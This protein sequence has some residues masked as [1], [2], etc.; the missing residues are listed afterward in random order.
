MAILKLQ[1][2]GETATLSIKAAEVVQGKFGPQVRFDT[3]DGDVLFIA[4]ETAERQLKRI[5]LTVEQCA[6]EVLTFSRDPN[7]QGGAP[8]WG[9]RVADAVE[10]SQPVESVRVPSPYGGKPIAGLDNFP[11]EAYGESVADP[12]PPLPATPAPTVAAQTRTT[13]TAAVAPVATDKMRIANSY[14]D[15]LKY[16]KVQTGLTDEQ[17]LQSATATVWIAW[18][19]GGLV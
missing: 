10:R 13:H 1:N 6:G 4:Q 18:T 7:K 16:M 2:E 12:T 19:K 17:A 15:L 14:V 11:S 9:I 3:T 5:P 8:Y